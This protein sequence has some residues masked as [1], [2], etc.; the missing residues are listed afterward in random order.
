MDKILIGLDLGTTLAKGLACD[1]KGQQLA[2]AS[3][4]I[5]TD[6]SALNAAEQDPKEWTAACVA[7]M[8]ELAQQLEERKRYITAISVSSHGPGAVLTDAVDQPLLPCAIWQD[9]RCAEDGYSLFAQVGYDWVGHGMPQTGLAARLHWL[10][11]TQPQAMAAARHIHDV[12]GYLLHFLTGS[13]VTEPSSNGGADQWDAALLTACGIDRSQLDRSL[14]ST[15][16][17]GLLRRELAQ[18]TGFPSAT[19]VVCGLND[20]AAAMLGSGSIQVG[21]GVVSVS[22]NGIARIVVDRKLPGRFLYDHSLFCWPYVAGR[23]VTGGFTKAAGD[24][25]Q[26]FIDIAY[27]DLPEAEQLPR[28]NQEAET[29]PPGANGVCFYPWLMGRGSPAA[30]EIPAGCFLGLARHH[31]RGDCSRAVLEGV[32]YALRDIGQQFRDMGYAW[33]KLRLTGGGMQSPLWRSIVVNVLGVEAR[34]V[35]T[36]SLLGAAILAGV[37]G[38]VYDSIESAC[39]ACVSLVND[40]TVLD[41]QLVAT[42]ERLYQAYVRAK[43]PLDD[44]LR[45]TKG[46][47]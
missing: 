41:R 17:A 1:I 2:L 18:S 12:K 40:P 14:P 13:Y 34:R 22:T 26:W 28:F 20:G 29:S 16:V 38:G 43:P 39:A 46:E 27:P 35:R 19:P 9:N 23:Y 24:L 5:A 44:Y 3:R 36:D 47:Q 30:T 7:I 32:A 37:G 10:S 25:V 21:Q 4:A 45:A 42:Y 11:R 15:A 31:T 6:R 8:R 33:D